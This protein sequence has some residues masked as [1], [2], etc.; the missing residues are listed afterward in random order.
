M[1]GF[2]DLAVTYTRLITT[3]S[4]ASTI[5]IEAG[6]GRGKTFF[7]EKWASALQADGGLVI[8]IDAQTSDHSG[9]PVVTFLGALLRAVPRDD[10]GR[11]AQNV[12]LAKRIGL[13]GAK[14]VGKA[15][16]REGA[17]EVGD[18]LAGDADGARADILRHITDDTAKGLSKSASDLID[19]QLA[20]EA[21]RD[22]IAGNLDR[23]HT[24]LVKDRDTDR[25]II[26]IDELDRCHPDYALALLEAMKLVF[27][28][29]GFVFVLFVNPDYLERLA[30]HRFGAQGEGEKYLDKFIDMRL[31]LPVNEDLLSKAVEHL[32]SDLP[33]KIPFGDHEEFSVARAARLAGEL[34][35]I[36]N[37]SL[38]QIKAV[39][40]KVRM[41]CV[42]YAERPID[43][44]LLVWLGFRD[45]GAADAFATKKIKSLSFKRGFLTPY[46][47]DRLKQSSSFE[48]PDGSHFVSPDAI[49]SALSSEYSVLSRLPVERFVAYE[50]SAHRNS[51]SWDDV[52]FGLAPHYIP[53]HEAM[54]ASVHKFAAPGTD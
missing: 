51:R 6:F 30:A 26:F 48:M 1:L 36:S 4:E 46:F 12:Q 16:L 24:A 29:P 9:D 41:A 49:N 40:F 7:R 10:P 28:H 5:S 23:L 27:Q 14:T 25:V 13:A 35:P 3:L 37:L 52:L 8:E 18:L 32:F 11:W 22:E 20:A 19:K 54:L 31:G 21:A 17:E 38:R 34:A 42:V 50:K 47:A 43:L 33:L 45:V 2:D 39:L 53:D 15:L 44:A